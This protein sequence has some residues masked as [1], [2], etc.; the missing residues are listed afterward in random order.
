MLS[1]YIMRELLV[2]EVDTIVNNERL[3]LIELFVWLPEY[4][5]FILVNQTLYRHKDETP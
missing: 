5:E 2:S 4:A 1:R 3:E